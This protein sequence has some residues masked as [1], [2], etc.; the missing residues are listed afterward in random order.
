MASANPVIFEEMPGVGGNLGVITLNRP[1][2]LNSLNQAMIHAMHERLLA[3]QENKAIKAVV[4]RAVPGRAFCA[5]GDIRA[6]YDYQLAGDTRANDFFRDEYALN[7][8]IFHYSK[9]YIALL[10]GITMGGGV[11]VSIHGSHRIGTE[12]LLF[13]M[14]ET[15]I[16]FFPDVGGTYF[17]PRLYDHVGYYLGL[18]GARIKQADCL[19]VGIIQHAMASN[20]L[21]DVLTTLASTTFKGDPFKAVTQLLEPFQA[22]VSQS[23]LQQAGSL[24][25][26]CFSKST[27]EDILKA[28]TEFKND[29]CQ[30]AIHTLLTKSP[31]SLKIT[32]KALQLGARL[33]F[34]VCMAQEYALAVHF[35]QS[36]DFRE[37]VRAVLIDKDQTPLWQPPS[38]AQVTENLVD[39]YF[40]P[41]H[42][43]KSVT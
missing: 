38:L 36:H 10:D 12:N 27:M 14:P 7:R 6:T 41:T 1:S 33:D 40:E 2:A 24:I 32:L 21:P 26:M 30:T 4:I 43:D 16:G 42:H 25:Q 11:G 34:D 29:F 31:S 13:A 17:L 39:H 37:G 9:P 19:A 15:G 22:E 28:L 18:T 3:W 23:P 8:C 5:G 20:R 35:N